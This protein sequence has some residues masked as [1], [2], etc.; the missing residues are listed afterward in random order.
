MEDLGDHGKRSIEY[1]SNEDQ[2]IYCSYILKNKKKE[3]FVFQYCKNIDALVLVFVAKTK[4][5]YAFN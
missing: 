1:K 2:G 4:Q 3:E 5:P